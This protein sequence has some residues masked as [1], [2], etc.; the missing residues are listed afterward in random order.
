MIKKKILEKSIGQLVDLGKKKG[1]L[2]YDEINHFL[3]EEIVSAEELDTV[4]DSLDNQNI[5]VL[6]A[7]EVDEWERRKEK[8]EEAVESLP[9]D[10]PV[11][12]YLR[13]MGQISLLSR[14]EELKLAKAIE[15][16]EEALRQEIFSTAIAKEVFLEV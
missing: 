13:Q 1:Y 9:I 11:K 2:T 12:M 6:E 8:R 10:D 14:E 4:F 3:S 15:E 7:K 5:S 16:R